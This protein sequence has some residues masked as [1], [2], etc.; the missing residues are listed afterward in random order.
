VRTTSNEITVKIRFDAEVRV[1][2]DESAMRQLTSL[3]NEK[4]IDVIPFIQDLA[5][6]RAISACSVVEDEDSGDVQETA[7]A[8]LLQASGL[9][10][11][12]AVLGNAWDSAKLAIGF[13]AEEV[14]E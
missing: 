1:S 6:K 13:V 10:S 14:T 12:E 2:F 9:E 5:A 3:L 8:E 7:L 11:E 4:D